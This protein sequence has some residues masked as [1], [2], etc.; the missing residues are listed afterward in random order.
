MECPCSPKEPCIVVLPDSFSGLFCRRTCLWKRGWFPVCWPLLASF[1]FVGVCL[2]DVP[3]LVRVQLAFLKSNFITS[4]QSGTKRDFRGCPFLEF[5]FRFNGFFYF[6]LTFSCRVFF[7]TESRRNKD[8]H[9]EEI[10][11]SDI[12]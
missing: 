4:P 7:F 2:S 12:K 6:F 9:T 5:L 11:L 8:K 3:F 1:G 10:Y